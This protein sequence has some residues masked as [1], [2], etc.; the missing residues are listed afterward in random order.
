MILDSP[1]LL[2]YLSDSLAVAAQ[3]VRPNGRR[4]LQRGAHEIS[5]FANWCHA[6]PFLS[7]DRDVAVLHGHAGTH[8]L[9][10]EI[11]P[12]TRHAGEPMNLIALITSIVACIFLGLVAFAVYLTGGRDD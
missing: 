3:E 8:C 11:A 9:A 6:I 2:S 4:S 5:L 12:T 10:F 1:R 7:L